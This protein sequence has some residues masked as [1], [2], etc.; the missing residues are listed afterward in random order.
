M[1]LQYEEARNIEIK[2]DNGANK[3]QVIIS[4]SLNKTT[5]SEKQTPIA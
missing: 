2:M 5:T 3:H 4:K 1:M